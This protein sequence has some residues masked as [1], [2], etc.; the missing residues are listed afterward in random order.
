MI[1]PAFI[2]ACVTTYVPVQE[3]LAP[4][5][6]GSARLLQFRVIPALVF[7]AIAGEVN[8]F[9]PGLRSVYLKVMMS[10]AFV[11]VVGEAVRVRTRGGVSTVAVASADVTTWVLK[12]AEAV[13]ILI[14]SPLMI[15]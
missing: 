9:A 5:L 7:V 2:S 11:T 4:D 3:V 1:E 10:P 14:T 8:E 13:A 6:R 12:R 15:S